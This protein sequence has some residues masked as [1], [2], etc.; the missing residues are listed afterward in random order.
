MKQ[1][2]LSTLFCALLSVIFGY[3][4]I[5]VLKSLKLG[6]PILKYVTS[7]K[8][9]SGTPT[10]GGIIFIIPLV[11]T[12]LIF[13]SGDK[14][15]SIFV[16]AVTVAFMTVGFLDDFLKI[17]LKRN[18]GLTPLQK[19]CFQVAISIIAS[20]VAYKSGQTFLNI[21]FTKKTLNIG[22]FTI[23]LNVLVFVAS[24]NAVNLTDGLDGLCASV[25]SVNLLY[26]SALIY[27]QVTAFKGIYVNESEYFNLSL[28]CL[29][30]VAGLLGYLLFNTQRASVFMGDTGSLAL[31][32]AI[33]GV[34]V[35]TGNALH[36]IFIGV[37]YLLSALSVIIQVAVYKRMKKRVFLMAPLHHHFQE[38]GYS[39]GKITYAYSFITFLI[40]LCLI[41][42]YF[43]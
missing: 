38:K 1:I 41:L 15:L 25:S 32:G 21:P 3:V 24:V 22:I 20:I 34:S 17:R 5:P 6:Q 33:S 18:E 43:W 11:I 39:E 40:G 16:L 12:F 7:H 23:I 9:K 2:I 14:R 26:F 30:L 10:M 37:F 13:S 4:F 8:T 42:V 36:V 35:I 31:G 29:N 19:I 28:F 27:L